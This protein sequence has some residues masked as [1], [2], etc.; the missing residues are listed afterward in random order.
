M[1]SSFSL[2]GLGSLSLSSPP[3]RRYGLRA[4]QCVCRI[5]DDWSCPDCG[6]LR[7]NFEMI[8]VD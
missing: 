5:S 2:L 4:S 7:E 3:A 6:A 8:E 1:K